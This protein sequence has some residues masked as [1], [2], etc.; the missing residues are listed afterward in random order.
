[1][2]GVTRP[3]EMGAGPIG[4]MRRADW[5][6]SRTAARLMPVSDWPLKPR[7]RRWRRN[8]PR[9]SPHPAAVHDE[10]VAVDVRRGGRGEEDGGAG[11][12]LRVAPAAGGD[13]FENL[14]V[15]RLVRDQRGVQVG[16]DV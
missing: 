8:C 11:D 4:G 9:S 6:G 2:H 3:R 10:Q 1:M 5:T 14:P 7:N 13:A 12:I 15:A 16:G